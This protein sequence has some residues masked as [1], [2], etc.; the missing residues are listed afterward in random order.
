MTELGSL[1]VGGSCVAW[2]VSKDTGPVTRFKSTACTG[3][4]ESIS[5]EGGYL[6]QLDTARK[7][8]V[9]SHCDLTN[10]VDSP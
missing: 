8:S 6:A 9:L 3:F 5:S 1:N 4:L 2:A 10:F 7:T